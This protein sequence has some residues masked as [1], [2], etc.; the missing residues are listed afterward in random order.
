M[1]I[2]RQLAAILSLTIAF[3]SQMSLSANAEEEIIIN[4]VSSSSV[5]SETQTVQEE[6]SGQKDLLPRVKLDYKGVEVVDASREVL[7]LSDGKK[8][9]IASG[10]KRTYNGMYVKGNKLDI[11]GTFAYNENQDLYLHVDASIELSLPEKSEDSPELA[12]KIASLPQTIMDGGGFDILKATDDILYLNNGMKVYVSSGKQH[13]T[14]VFKEGNDYCFSGTFAYDKDEDMYYNVDSEMYLVYYCGNFCVAGWEEQDEDGNWVEVTET[15]T[16]T[17]VED[18]TTATTTTTAYQP[19]ERII[20]KKTQPEGKYPIKYYDFVYYWV[21][22]E[23]TVQELDFGY[24]VDVDGTKWDF[25]GGNHNIY[26]LGRGDVIKIE[27][28][29][30]YSPDEDVF[31]NFN[32][33]YELISESNDYEKYATIEIKDDFPHFI[34]DKRLAADHMLQYQVDLDDVEITKVKELEFDEVIMTVTGGYEFIYSPYCHGCGTLNVGDHISV[35]G[36]FEYGDYGEDGKW[37][38][39]TSYQIDE[40]MAGRY[41]VV[42]KAGKAPKAE[43]KDAPGKKGDANIDNVVDLSDVVFIMQTM[44]NPN[45]YELTPEG[46]ENADVSNTGNGVTL[47]DASVIQIGLL[48][49]EF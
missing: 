17:Y 3:S 35:H 10:E 32:A 38:T 2:K 19:Q 25:F 6:T 16:T 8:L 45:K 37:Y 30:W 48:N 4:N 39:P 31:G 11:S 34:I 1:N 5:D 26:E 9:Y 28:L 42:S 24:V 23:V 27:G 12:A 33:D 14:G 47:E 44:A 20:S 13:Y 29:F 46:R 15:T 7:T 18:I 41:S 21:D 49:G 43:R 22:K 36:R 40:S